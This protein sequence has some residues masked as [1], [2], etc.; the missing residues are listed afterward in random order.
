MKRV[1]KYLHKISREYGT[2]SVIEKWTLRGCCKEISM[3][4]IRFRPWKI[5]GREREANGEGFYSEFV[6][7]YWEISS[8]I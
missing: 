2:L 3:E 4:Y 5:G 7:N 6:F 8:V 1:Q